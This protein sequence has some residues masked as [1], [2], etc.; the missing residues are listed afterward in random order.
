MIR[1]KSP[2]SE[3]ISEIMK[4]INFEIFF[5]NLKREIMLKISCSTFW[6][7][8]SKIETD[9]KFGANLAHFEAKADIP[10]SLI[11]I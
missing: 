10:E 4:S 3:L 11:W 9:L 1:E 6:L 5:K 2:P 8:W 7:A